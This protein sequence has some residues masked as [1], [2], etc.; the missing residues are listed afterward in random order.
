MEP[1]LTAGAGSFQVGP[2]M[3][4]DSAISLLLGFIS[5]IMQS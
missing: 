4:F 3:S 1:D 2:F 5:G